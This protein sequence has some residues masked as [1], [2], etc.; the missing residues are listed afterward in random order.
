MTISTQFHRAGI[1]SCRDNTVL[2]YAILRSSYTS[3]RSMCI[4]TLDIT[5]VFD[6]VDHTPLLVA[7]EAAGLPSERITY[8]QDNYQRRTPRCRDADG[9]LRH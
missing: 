8:L 6:S 9:N 3:F 2:L 5:K 4:A 7:T 1:D